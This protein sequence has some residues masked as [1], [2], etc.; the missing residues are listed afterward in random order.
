MV[1]ALT[2]SQA[3]CITVM[4][5][6]LLVTGEVFRTEV[7]KKLG[8]EVSPVEFSNDE[9]IQE[10]QELYKDEYKQLLDVVPDSLILTMR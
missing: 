5:G 3:V 2:V 7:T 9:F 6:H 4:T 1:R 10:V 8:R